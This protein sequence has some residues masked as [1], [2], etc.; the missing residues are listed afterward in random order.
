LIAGGTV[1]RA[2]SPVRRKGTHPSSGALLMLGSPKA[3]AVLP[4]ILE[5]HRK[6]PHRSRIHALVPRQTGNRRLEFLA[7]D[8]L[9]D[10]FHGLRLQKRFA[11][12][13]EIILGDQSN[14]IEV[15]L[16]AASTPKLTSA[17]PLAT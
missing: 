9:Q 4:K 6:G 13:E 16:A 15:E 17:M 1:D 11:A 8:N 3:V 7:S 12:D 10:A 5:D 2:M 14:E